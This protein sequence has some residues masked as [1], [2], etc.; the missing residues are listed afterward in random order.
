MG[1]KIKHTHGEYPSKNVNSHSHFNG[2]SSSDVKRLNCCFNYMNELES[3][4]VNAKSDEVIPGIYNEREIRKND[5]L[6]NAYKVSDE[7]SMN[8]FLK[9]KCIVKEYYDAFNS[10]FRDQDKLYE[11]NSIEV[12]KDIIE[13]VF[14]DNGKDNDIKS[15]GV[16]INNCG[17]KVSD[18]LYEEKDTVDLT[19]TIKKLKLRFKD[20]LNKT[21]KAEVKRLKMKTSQIHN[22]DDLLNQQKKQ[23]EVSEQFDMLEW[24]K[25]KKASHIEFR[26]KSMSKNFHMW[27]W[28]KG[29]NT[30]RENCEFTHRKRNF[31]IWKSHLRKKEKTGSCAKLV[32]Y[33][34][35]EVLVDQKMVQNGVKMVEYGMN[36][37]GKEY[38]WV[39]MFALGVVVKVLVP[40]QTAKTSVQLTSGE[41]SLM[42][43]TN[44]S[45]LSAKVE[46]E[47]ISTIAKKVLD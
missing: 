43:K 2:V 18:K 20:A 31:D 9:R 22:D 8:K 3:S 27:K 44:L 33:W 4:V 42:W 15:S 26:F 6:G 12:K 16:V 19:S 5:D 14:H 7:L 30:G 45:T 46:V 37:Q 34:N 38:L 40:K 25:R 36:K 28:R 23:K 32:F 35:Q 29:N 41:Q 1:G 21:L 17:L 13:L 24:R 39:K 47:L 11:E 10:S